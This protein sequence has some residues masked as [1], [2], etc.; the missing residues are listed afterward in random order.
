[1]SAPARHATRSSAR[2]GCTRRIGSSRWS[3]TAVGPMGAGRSGWG[4]RAWRATSSSAASASRRVRVSTGSTR[5]R[6]ARDARGLRRRRQRLHGQHETA[7]ASSSTSSARGPSPGDPW[8]SMAVFKV[9]HLRH[10][11]VESQAL[12]RA[13][14]QV[15][16]P[17]ARRR[18]HAPAAAASDADR[19]ARG[20]V[21]RGAPR[22]ARGD[23]ATHLGDGRSC[24]AH[25]RAATTGRSAAGAL[26]PASRSS[27]G[28]RTGRSTCPTC[29][30]RTTSPAPSGTPSG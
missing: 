22:R 21:P 6:C 13:T 9:R 1:M 4:R 5:V 7:G 24:P 23:G 19:P 20:R 12:A 17:R 30:T 10:G 27:R 28:T 11:P 26:P 18:P 2:A 25:P 16:G 29:T 15:R 8:D 3:T 14:A